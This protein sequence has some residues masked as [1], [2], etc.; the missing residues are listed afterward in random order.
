[1]ARVNPQE[2]DPDRYE[3]VKREQEEIRRQCKG[4]MTLIRTCP[5]CGHRIEQVARGTHGYTFTKC[6]HCGEEVAFP[7]VSFRL[8]R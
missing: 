4:L 8:A 5:Y 7:P 2:Y 1:M 3:A 6:P